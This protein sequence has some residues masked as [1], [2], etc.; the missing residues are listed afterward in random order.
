MQF[1]EVGPVVSVNE[2]PVSAGFSKSAA[3]RR[4]VL[5]ALC[6]V[7]VSLALVFGLRELGR[8]LLDVPVNLKTLETKGLLPTAIA[9]VIGNSFGYLM[10]FIV[11]P[12]RHS[13]LL[14]LLGA[15]TFLVL[16]TVIVSTTLPGSASAGSVITTVVIVLVPNSIVPVLPMLVPRAPERARARAA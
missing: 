15:A 6:G 1:G 8:Q 3:V 2:V 10:S 14:Y 7:A 12:G 4:L 5:V 9:P 11:R 13:M 16:S